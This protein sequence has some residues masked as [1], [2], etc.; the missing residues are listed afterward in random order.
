MFARKTDST[1]LEKAIKDV[2][3]QMEVMTA[4]DEDYAKMVKQLTELMKLRQYETK[5]MFS[6]DV[7]LTVGANLFGIILILQHERTNV[8]A[9][10]AIGFVA[11]LR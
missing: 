5:P 3:S 7:M 6:P 2:H 1:L 9:S 10:K 8:I 4:D 11:K